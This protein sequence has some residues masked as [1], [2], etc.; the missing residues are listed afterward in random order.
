MPAG[1]ALYAALPG[2]WQVGF[3]GQR[4]IGQSAE[5]PLSCKLEVPGN[6]L[7]LFHQTYLSMKGLI[8]LTLEPAERP[9]MNL[10]R[11]RLG[12]KPQGRHSSLVPLLSQKVWGW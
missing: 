6:D 2:T 9:D 12:Y 7:T 11:G 10:V 1:I 4:Q 5:A 3:R 8:H